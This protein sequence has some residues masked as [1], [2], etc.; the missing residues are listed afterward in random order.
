MKKIYFLLT[1][2]MAFTMM[3]AQSPILTAI[4]DGDCSGGNPKVVEMYANGTVDF[5]MYSLE[6]QSNGG[7]WGST[8]NLAELGTVTDAFVYVYSDSNDPEVFVSEFPSVTTAW[9]NGVVNINGDD[10]IRIVMDSDMSVVDQFGAD[11]VDGTDTAWEYKDGYAKRNNGTGPDGTF[12]ETNWTYANGAFDGG[13]TCQGGD[14]FETIMGGIGTFTMDGGSTDPSIAITYPSN[15][16]TLALGTTE[17]DVTFVTSNFEIGATDAG[18]DGHVHYYLNGD[19]L[20][21]HYSNDPISYT[22]LVPGTHTIKLQLVDNSHQPF[23]PDIFTESTFTIPSSMSVATIAELRAGAQD[24]SVYT[25]TGEAI[26]TM[27]QAYRNQKWIEDATAAILVDDNSGNITTEY[28]MYD[29]ITGISGTLTEYNGVMQFVPTEDPGAASSTGNMMEPQVVAI[30]D[31]NANPEMYESE[32]VKFENVYTDETG[33]WETGTN[34]A[35]M[36]S[37]VPEDILSVR[38][39]FYSADYIGTE[40]PSGAVHLTGIAGEYQGAAQMYPRDA[41]DIATMGVNDIA[42]NA[43]N[44]KVAVANNQLQIT[45]FDAENVVIYNIKGQKVSNNTFVGSLGAGVYIAVMRN[46]DGQMVSVKFIKK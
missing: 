35:F 36:S 23:D 11:G 16:A 25:L 40:L 33:N 1:M 28:N 10:G 8:T 19:F 6:K 22:G 5:S 26:L 3:N 15:G 30:A 31:F 44:I 29:G 45:G 12:I 7:D 17:I 41:E 18:L 42:I 21:M 32:L 13:G 34:Y 27:Q 2:F 46:V 9:E 24:G 4:G 39:N 20:G 43:K 38:T 14:T 37:D